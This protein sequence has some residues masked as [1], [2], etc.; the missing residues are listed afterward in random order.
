MKINV[1]IQPRFRLPLIVWIL[2][3][4]I[5]IAFVVAMVRYVFGIGAISNLNNAYPWGFW[6]SFDLYTGIAISSGAFIITSV[7]YIFELEQFRPLIRPTL[8][9]GLL[10]YIM[11]VIALLVDLGHPERIWHYFIYQNFTS[12]LLVIGLYVMAYSAIMMVEFAPAI[13]ERLKW[14]KQ[15]AFIRRFMKPLVIIGAVISTLHQGALGALL[16]IQPTKLHPLWW[17]AILPELFFTSALAIGLGM[18]IFEST[19]SSRYFKRGLESHLLEKIGKA[20]PVILGIYLVLKFGEILWAGDMQYLFSSGWMSVLFWAEILLSAA[21]PLVWF[22]IKRI[23]QNPNGLFAGAIML[24]VGMI[25][26]RFNV[27]WF[28]VQ[29]AD[30]ITYIPTFMS[31]VKYFPSLPEVAISIGIFAAGIL[32]F[33]LA[34]KYLPVF[35][36]EGEKGHLPAGD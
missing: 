22:S 27:S 23:R 6:V 4:L 33:G 11:E 31:N 18:I 14:E 24:L 17:T 1:T 7:V 29:H 15:A 25:F 35:D 26:N 3:G 28:A 13:F 30:P 10:G 36:D 34:V 32:A 20:I 8:L 16:L 21:I 5:G 19:L 12:F 9:T 2:L